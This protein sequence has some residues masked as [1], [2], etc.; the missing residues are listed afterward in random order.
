[1][2]RELDAVGEEIEA[3]LPHCPLVRPQ[4][5]HVRL[6]QLVDGDAAVAGAQLE[7][8]VAVLDHARERYRLLV[9]LIAAGLDA[10]EVED[11]VDEVEQMHAGIMDVG[12]IVLVGRHRMRPEDLALHHLGEAEDGVER[13]AQLMA[14]LCEKARLGDVG[15]LGAAARLVGDRFRL[16]ELADECILLRARLERR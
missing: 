11:L 13:R 5:R 16:L 1:L 8:V 12:G 14:H 4:P 3:D 10:R 6:E 15:G 2:R 7:Q 9:E